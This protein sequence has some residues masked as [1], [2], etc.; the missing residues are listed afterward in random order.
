MAGGKKSEIIFNQPGNL[1]SSFPQFYYLLLTMH[2]YI[3]DESQERMIA[4]SLCVRISRQLTV[5][6]LQMRAIS[7]EWDVCTTANN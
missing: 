1:P 6:N 2:L 7:C 3:D 4:R 5:A